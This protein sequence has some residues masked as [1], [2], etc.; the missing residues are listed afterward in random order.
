M[1]TAEIAI[2][3]RLAAMEYHTVESHVALRKNEKNF[4][5]LM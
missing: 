5:E 3:M 1:L 2:C 4:S